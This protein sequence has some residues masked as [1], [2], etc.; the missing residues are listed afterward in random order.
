MVG[1]RVVTAVCLSAALGAS[2]ASAQEP[3]DVLAKNGLTK[4]KTYFVIASEQP[5]LQKLYNLKPVMGQMQQKYMALAAIYQ[6][7]YEL[8]VLNDYRIQV[9]SLLDDVRRQVNAMPSSNLVQRQQREEARLYQTQVEQE[10]RDTD[11]QIQRR[12]N[13][14]VSPAAK[15]KTEQDFLERRD[16]FVKAKNQMWPMVDDTLK[17]YAQ[18]DQNDSV[19]NALRAYNQEVKA[20]LRLGPSDVLKK[21]AQQVVAYEQ[22]FSP[23]TAS[24]PKKMAKRKG[25]QM[26]KKK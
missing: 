22:N 18:L 8:Q 25:L 12:R 24:K 1:R 10:L 20:H 11:T 6:N 9:N 5:V 16:A 26:K 2:V 14:R 7:E 15:E 13:M 23:E 21:S 17:Q 19:K 3:I 4:S